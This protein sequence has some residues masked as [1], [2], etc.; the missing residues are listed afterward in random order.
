MKEP[1]QAHGC[2]ASAK[3]DPATKK[4]RP[5]CCLHWLQLDPKLRNEI[6]KGAA[7]RV[8]LARAILEELDKHNAHESAVQNG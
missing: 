4:E 1:C 2:K 3:P 6:N 5:F 7:G 8:A